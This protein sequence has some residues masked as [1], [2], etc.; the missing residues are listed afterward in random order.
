MLGKEGLT[1]EKRV[2][3]LFLLASA[4]GKTANILGLSREL[5]EAA[6]QCVASAQIVFLACRQHR[7]YSADELKE[8]FE[9]QGRMFFKSLE[10]LWDE[11]QRKVGSLTLSLH[12]YINDT[13]MTNVVLTYT[14][15]LRFSEQMPYKLLAAGKMSDQKGHSLAI[16]GTCAHTYFLVVHSENFMTSRLHQGR[17]REQ[18]R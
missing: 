12:L 2:I 7:P 9:I 15:P 6:I 4:L 3:L 11:G 17:K 5:S 10:K 13:Y 16:L 8:I 18:H 14:L 1:A